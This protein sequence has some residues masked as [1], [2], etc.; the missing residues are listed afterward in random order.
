MLGFES[1]QTKKSRGTHLSQQTETNHT[2]T[3]VSDLSARLLKG[4]NI[5]YNTS[6]PRSEKRSDISSSNSSS[7]SSGSSSSG[8]SRDDDEDSRK[9]STSGV[10]RVFYAASSR[11]I[12]SITK[13]AAERLS[14]R[15]ACF[16]RRKIDELRYAASMVKEDLEKGGL[17]FPSI[18]AEKPRALEGYDIN[19]SCIRLLSAKS[20]ADSPFLTKIAGKGSF[21]SMT[22]LDQLFTETQQVYNKPWIQADAFD[23]GEK[24]SAGSLTSD[25]ESTRTMDI[26]ALLE[27][28]IE[29]KAS[30]ADAHKSDAAFLQTISM[31]SA[32]EN[33]SEPR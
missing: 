27:D 28:A 21:Q 20:V 23:W 19:M 32:L 11:K 7:S 26:P 12:D 5:T 2:T 4:Y 24:S 13:H 31:G 15:D 1:P 17:P 18:H 6:T 9:R 33:S 14:N 25:S 10:R 29:L 8:S 30:E 22:D 16:K 3:M